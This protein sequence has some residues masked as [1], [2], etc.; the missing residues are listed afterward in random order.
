MTHD[1][2]HEELV[3][4]RG[5]VWRHGV[6][7]TFRGKPLAEVGQRVIAIAEGGLER[8]GRKRSDGK[9]ERVHLTRL[10]ELVGRGMSPADRLLEGMAL[11]AGSEFR[12]EVMRRSDLA[13]R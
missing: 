7:A 11:K 1:W 5:D 13:V 6:R 8:R 10:R 2:T 4:L 9:D 3:A 12:R